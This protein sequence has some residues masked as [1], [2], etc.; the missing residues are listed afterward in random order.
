MQQHQGK[1]NEA[2]SNYGRTNRWAQHGLGAA[3]FQSQH[4]PSI[5]ATVTLNW[6][7]HFLWLSAEDSTDTFETP[8]HVGYW[9]LFY[10][11]EAIWFRYKSEPQK[12]G[13]PRFNGQNGGCWYCFSICHL[14]MRHTV[15]ELLPSFGIVE[16]H[17]IEFQYEK[18]RHASQFTEWTIVKIF[19]N[20][21]LPLERPTRHKRMTFSALWMVGTLEMPVTDE[22]HTV[23]LW[24]LFGSPVMF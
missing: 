3:L 8:G 9:F 10:N 20:C 16:R 4:K 23:Y 2:E 6:K 1:W 19:V 14:I 12:E 18:I 13:L 11:L 22:S 17:N 7:T 24:G 15:K 5:I 21:Q